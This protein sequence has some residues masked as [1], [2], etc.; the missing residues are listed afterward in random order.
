MTAAVYTPL[1]AS[2]NKRQYP[3]TQDQLNSLVLSTGVV[4]FS[5]LTQ[6]LAPYLL[7]SSLAGSLAPYVT[8]ASLTATLA[9][10]PLLS[11]NNVWT[12]KQQFK[13]LP[14]ADVTAYGAVSG[15]DSTAAIQA[16]IDHMNGVYTGGIV[17]LPPGVYITSSA[18]LTVKGGV[19]LMG[20]GRKATAIFGTAQDATVITFDGSC[21]YAELR[22]LEVGGYQNSLA[23]KPA[24]LISNGVAVDMYKVNI[25]GGTYAIQNGGV[26]GRFYDIFAMGYTGA[27][28]TTGGNFYTDCKFDDP[29]GFN[30]LYAMNFST[31]YAGAFVVE[32]QI[33]DT[34]MGGLRNSILINDANQLRRCKFIGCLPASPVAIVNHGWTLLSGCEIGSTTWSLTTTNPITVMGCYQQGGTVTLGGA[35]VIKS[36]NFQIV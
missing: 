27:V 2:L 28:F 4:T 5:S 17:F 33:L 6:A 8:T 3:V 1:L 21:V 18:G 14:W 36:A 29:G 22:D 26:D 12:G 19:I 34:D 31:Y 10:F 11:G 9:A 23:T 32:D 35:N 13:D 25:F 16:A 7:I 30:P 24:T 15:Q 20:S